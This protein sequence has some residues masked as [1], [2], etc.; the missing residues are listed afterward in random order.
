VRSYKVPL[1]AV[2]VRLEGAEDDEM[3]TL[4]EIL[5]SQNLPL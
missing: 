4:G 5:E 2:M 3:F 1:D